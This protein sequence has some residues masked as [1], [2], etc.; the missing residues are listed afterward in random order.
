MSTTAD[1][2]S[3]GKPSLRYNAGFATMMTITFCM[4]A[5]APTPIYRL[6]QQTL[7][8]TPFEIT[9]VFAIYSFTIVAA[10]LTVARLSDFVGRKPMA[11]AA[12][13]LNALALV[14]FLLADSSASLIA[15][16]ATQGFAT[17]IALSTLG[18]MIADAAPR[19]AATLNS[20]TAF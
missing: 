15:A 9:L 16:R 8:L 17:G 11:M 6:Y 4:A 12:L 1:A 3:T 18:A 20:V 14:Q 5:S 10:F 2:V 13:V 19:A 7:G